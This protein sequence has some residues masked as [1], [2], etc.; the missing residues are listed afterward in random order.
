MTTAATDN[1]ESAGMRIGINYGR[2]HLDVTV[3]EGSLVGVRRAQPAPPLADP[4]AT[5]GTALE[6][7]HDF[8]ALRLALTPDDHVAIVV[9]EH[10]PHFVELLT[11]VLEH[12][13]RASVAPEAIT[14]LC[15]QSS[16]G[17]PWLEELPDEFQDV[18][19][20]VHD[21]ADRRHLSYLATT[22]HGRRIYLNRTVVDADQVVVLSGWGYDPALGT[23]GGETA[24][25]PALS[26]QATR[27]ETGGDGAG[28]G[29]AI[30][31]AA[32]RREAAEVAWL[33]GVPFLVQVIEGA[34][35]DI[36]HVVAGPVDTSAEG[37]R[38]QE[39]RWR[40][41]V[42]RPADTM[43]VTLSGDPA[44]HDFADLA[45][46]LACATRVV[47]PG[48]RIVLLSGATPA[49]GPGAELLR[50][51]DDPEQALALLREQRP[52][53]L[54]AARL[55]AEAA[56]HAQIYLLSGLPQETAEELFTVPLDH[57]GQ[58]QR[59]LDAEGTC[60][61]LEDGHKVMAALVDSESGRSKEQTHA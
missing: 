51:A 43:I 54:A 44:R 1:Q 55:W 49:L 57:A 41:D 5:V 18:H 14:V 24:L 7:P 20:E 15:P 42:E 12:I 23:A 17:Q 25:Y 33:L 27:E 52:P 36:A 60:L 46:A 9:E 28:E 48:G 30:K 4:A 19:V 22:K 35:E 6:S 26:D 29:G 21:P 45:R 34:G 53:D 11:A 16:A 38:L 56:R 50:Q 58:V 59:L 37:E 47:Q 8:P 61:V 2:E 32:L 13:R 39:A 3:R 10:L 40:V 31:P